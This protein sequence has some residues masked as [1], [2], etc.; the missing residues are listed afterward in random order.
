MNI[1]ENRIKKMLYLNDQ[2]KK[3]YGNM[4]DIRYREWMKYNS[5]ISTAVL[6]II[7]AENCY[8]FIILRYI[9]YL[10]ITQI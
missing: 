5:K 6:N 1:D 10:E 3:M 7:N 8:W 9:N 4:K 2:I